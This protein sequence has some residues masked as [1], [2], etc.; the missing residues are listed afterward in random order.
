[1]IGRRVHLLLLML[2]AFVASAGIAVS[3]AH[4]QDK[5]QAIEREI[6]EARE[7]LTRLEADRGD[8]ERAEQRNLEEQKTASEGAL[9]ALKREGDR[10]AGELNT[11]RD[12]IKAQLLLIDRKN[13][14]LR[15]AAHTAAKTGVETAEAEEK[16]GRNKQADEALDSAKLNTSRWK[17]AARAVKLYTHV[18]SAK[19]KNKA[20]NIEAA[21]ARSER[22]EL[23]A[24]LDRLRREEQW[25]KTETDDIDELLK[26]TLKA[27]GWPDV[28]EKLQDLQKEL[29]S[30]RTDALDRIAKCVTRQKS[31]DDF[32][33]MGK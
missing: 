5:T 9:K 12:K 13:G 16:A 25:L 17:T 26:R 4:A 22:A 14:E 33:G 18:E 3:P 31:I 32:L 30:S 27:R 6:Q 1:M 23:I 11:L 20:S 15:S 19:L 8:K 2:A 10:I 29:K 21:Q 7:A 24:G 28:K